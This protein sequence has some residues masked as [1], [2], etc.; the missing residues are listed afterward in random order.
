MY[1]QAGQ[2]W[3]RSKGPWQIPRECGKVYVGQTGRS[4]EAKCKEHMRHVHLKQ[5]DK[6]V[7]AK[8]NFNTGHC[9]D[10]SSTSVL[11]KTTGYME[12][13]VK[14][15]TEIRLNTR[16]FNRD[17]G[18]ILSRAWYPVINMLSNQKAGQALDST[19]QSPLASVQ[20][21]TQGSGRCIY[22]MDGNSSH[23][24][25]LRTRTEMVL[26]MLVFSP[27]NHLKQLV[28]QEDFIIIL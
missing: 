24:S 28:A 6:P 8:H 20:P 27:F 13:I 10:F 1:D 5:H 15:A 23:F 22:D 9:I 2:G 17:G 26:E 11:D 14:E 12:R 18:F 7:V 25:T 4:I 3:L 21:W 16:N 19:H